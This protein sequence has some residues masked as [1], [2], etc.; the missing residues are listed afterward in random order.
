[1]RHKIALLVSAALTAGILVVIAG[2]VII[3]SNIGQ[4]SAQAGQD[5]ASV[6]LPALD[7]AQQQQ[8]SDRESAYRQLIEEANTRLQQA[9]Q[10][11]DALRAQLEN[12]ANGGSGA[13]QGITPQQAAAVA[14]SF[15]GQSDVY[16]VDSLDQDGTRLYLVTFSSGDQVYVDLN[17]QV[18]ASRISSS[19]FNTGAAGGNVFRGEHEEEHDDDD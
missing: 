12:L 13:A 7:S 10:E 4:A 16:T 14:A 11:N 1:M 18:V 8:L 2:L 17:G 15:V 3:V 9:Q 6:A 19:A 5:S